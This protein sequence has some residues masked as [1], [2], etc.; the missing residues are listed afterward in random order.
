MKTYIRVI[1]FV[2]FFL[3]LAGILTGLYFYNLKDPDLAKAKP[4]F[5]L[6][7][8]ELQKAFEADETSATS[9]YVNRILEVTGKIR[10]VSPAKNNVV[11]ISLETGSDLSSVIATFPGINDPSA[12]RAGE[13]I[14]FRGKC[15]G[16]LMD[17][18]LNNCAVVNIKTSSK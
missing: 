11:S 16:F 9:K 10:N 6:S 15:S 3:A 2:V 4:D 1:L 5:T 14:S 7:A 8:A 13:E 12:F 17:V 18:L